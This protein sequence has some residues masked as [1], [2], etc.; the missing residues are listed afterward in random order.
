MSKETSPVLSLVWILRQM[1]NKEKDYLM[2]RV[3]TFLE[4]IISNEKQVKAAKDITR[5]IFYEKNHY[6]D[7]NTVLN[8]FRNKYCPKIEDGYKYTLKGTDDVPGIEN[9]FPEEK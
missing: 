5:S 7:F 4:S 6:C 8:Q 2:G 3:L 9:Y 1:R